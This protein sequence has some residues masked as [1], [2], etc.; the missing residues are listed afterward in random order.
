VAKLT[1]GSKIRTLREEKGLSQ[2]ELAQ[3]MGYKSK[4]SIHKIEQDVTDLPLS[5]VNEFAKILGISPAYLMGWDEHISDSEFKEM[6][7]FLNPYWVGVKYVEDRNLGEQYEIITYRDED[8]GEIRNE[9]FQKYLELKDLNEDDVAYEISK[10]FSKKKNYS[11]LTRLEKYDKEHKEEIERL[12]KEVED[13]EN[14][15]DLVKRI[16]VLLAIQ[17]KTISDLEDIAKFKRGTIEKWNRNLPITPK[18]Q[19]VADIL[20]TS[21]NYLISGDDEN[22]ENILFVAR[23]AQDLNPKNLELI[24]MTMKTLLES[25][26]K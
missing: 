19:K 23:K 5:K 11:K 13:I 3:K 7:A 12:S 21:L 1:I 6:M 24:K 15:S 17:G 9:L 25:Q 14:S 18:I 26:G 16:K 20:N 8:Y 22:Q 2:E 10:F 4:T